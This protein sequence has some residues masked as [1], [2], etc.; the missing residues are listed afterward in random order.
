MV[1]DNTLIQLWVFALIMLVLTSMNRR[2][3]QEGENSSASSCKKLER[4]EYDEKGE[5]GIGDA[6]GKLAWQ[7]V[8]EGTN[9]SHEDACYL[10]KE[11]ENDFVSRL[12]KRVDAMAECTDP[13]TGILLQKHTVRFTRDYDD[14]IRAVDKMASDTG[15]NPEPLKNLLEKLKLMVTDS[16][17]KGEIPN[18]EYIKE[19]FAAFLRAFCKDINAPKKPMFTLG[20]IGVLGEK[21]G[22]WG[23][24]QRKQ[25]VVEEEEE[26]DAK[27][28]VTYTK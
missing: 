11:I 13:H 5:E 1:Q 26:E 22:L 27:E 21:F 12:E 2:E 10:L 16:I 24:E 3:G 4:V 25:M 20:A 19:Q 8:Y 17:E 14:I 15:I 6:M 23:R 18:F 28:T 9:N 7:G